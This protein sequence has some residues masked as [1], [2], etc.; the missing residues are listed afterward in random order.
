[1]AT[2][3]DWGFIKQGGVYQYKED[4]IIL[5]VEI[6][7]DNSTDNEYVFKLRPIAGTFKVTEPFEIRFP[8]SFTGRYSGQMQFYDEPEYIPLPL[9]TKWPFIFDNKVLS[10][11]KYCFDNVLYSGLLKG[12]HNEI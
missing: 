6:L 5:I 8:K 2:V 11:S 10:T 1:M 7:E 9:G 3:Q 12:K 4:Y